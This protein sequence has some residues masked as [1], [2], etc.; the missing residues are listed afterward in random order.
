[1]AVLWH[2]AR[3]RFLVRKGL[4]ARQTVILS[5]FRTC[6]PSPASHPRRKEAAK[7]RQIECNNTPH[8]K[9]KTFPPSCWRRPK[10]RNHKN[11]FSCGEPIKKR[12]KQE[13][14][15]SEKVMF[16]V[17]LTFRPAKG[18]RKHTKR[19]R[20]KLKCVVFLLYTCR[21][22]AFSPWWMRGSVFC[23]FAPKLHLHN[24]AQISH[25]TFNASIKSITYFI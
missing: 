23:N 21:V 1:M 25:H 16:V 19:G 2:D 22:F 13:S 24:V 8:H 18:K 3:A 10:G 17:I 20:R 9:T 15:K 5:Y 12:K 7:S 14:W 6:T 11:K 4:Q